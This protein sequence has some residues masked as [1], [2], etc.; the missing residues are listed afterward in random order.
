MKWDIDKAVAS[1]EGSGV[2]GTSFS[3]VELGDVE[4][5][6]R[7]LGKAVTAADRERGHVL[8]WCLSLGL[9]P[10]PKLFFYERTLHRLYLK[11]RRAVRSLSTEDLEYYGLKAPNRRK[12]RTNGRS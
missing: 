1:L 7:Y 4:V 2:C 10:Y 9:I 8:V 3:R 11:T 12:R 6:E 5:M